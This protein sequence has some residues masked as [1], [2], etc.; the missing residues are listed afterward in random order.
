MAWDWDSV[1]SYRLRKEEL[2]DYLREKFGNYNFYTQVGVFH[3][4]LDIRWNV[5]TNAAC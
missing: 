5:W 4:R 1:P 3:F 2:E